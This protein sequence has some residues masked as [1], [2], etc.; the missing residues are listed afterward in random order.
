MCDD[1]ASQAGQVPPK[2]FLLQLAGESG[3]GK[4]TLAARIS[5]RTGAVV[6]D[7]DVVK[8]TAL[9]AGADWQL[10]GRMSHR[11]LNSLADSLLGQG[12]SVILDR[13]CRFEQIVTDSMAVADRR[14][15]TYCF[16]ECVLDD[17]AELG[18]RI[19]TRERLRSQMVDY[20]ISSPDASAGA[21]MAELRRDHGPEAFITKY[22]PTPWLQIDTKLEPER[23]LESALKY[24][25]ARLEQSH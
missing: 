22:P 11:S 8:S 19:R 5:A 16:I 14:D 2:L 20:G 10:A 4:S 23:C 15:A 18:R 21:S 25:Y 13:P 9:D 24:L 17:K 7:M 1:S 3:G 12:F 6:L